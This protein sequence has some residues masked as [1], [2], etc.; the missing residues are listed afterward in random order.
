MEEYESYV[1]PKRSLLQSNQL[2]NTQVLSIY[3]SAISDQIANYLG[4]M[5][6]LFILPLFTLYGIYVNSC[7]Y[8]NSVIPYTRLPFTNT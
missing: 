3:Y 6:K 2:G 1:S 5:F 7:T 4:F 8:I